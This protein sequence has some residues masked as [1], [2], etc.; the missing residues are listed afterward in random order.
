MTV[1]QPEIEKLKEDF[2]QITKSTAEE[3]PADFYAYLHL[4]GN[5]R[6]EKLISYLELNDT[7]S[8]KL[9]WSEIK[10]YLDDEND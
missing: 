4:L 3:N 8:H 1:T 10:N 5:S 7:I 6:I 9:T 2:N